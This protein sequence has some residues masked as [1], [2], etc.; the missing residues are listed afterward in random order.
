MPPAPGEPVAGGIDAT[1]RADAPD[2]RALRP[3][4]PCLEGPAHHRCDGPVL[5]AHGVHHRPAGPARLLVDGPP[6]AR[7]RDVLRALGVP[8]LPAVRDRQPRRPLGGRRWQRFQKSRAF[9]VIPAYWVALTLLIIFFRAES[10]TIRSRAASRSTA[11]SD[12]LLVYGFA[13]VYVPKYF[14]HGITSAYTL[15]AEVIFYLPDPRVR[16]AHPALVPGLHP[17]PEAPPRAHRAR[18]G[19]A[20]SFAWRAV[21]EWGYADDARELHRRRARASSRARRRSGSPATPTTSRSAWP[22]P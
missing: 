19:A 10:R 13:Q 7:P 15:D 6:R 5:P 2:P 20:G 18:A 11:G 14:F 22:S 21:L 1:A 16:A 3:H 9:R 17:R 12:A 8:A 4:Y